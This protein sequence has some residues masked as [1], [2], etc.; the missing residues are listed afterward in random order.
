[1]SPAQIQEDVLGGMY[2]HLERR[3]EGLFLRFTVGDDGDRR[4]LAAYV[5]ELVARFE[6][7]GTRVVG[8]EIVVGEPD[9]R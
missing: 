5:D 3:N 4:T 1:M 2:L 7:K 8:Y 6:K 9:A